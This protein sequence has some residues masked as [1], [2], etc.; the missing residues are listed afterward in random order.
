[1]RVEVVFLPRYL[2]PTHLQ[3]KTVVVFDVLRA[4]TSMAA[5]LAAGVTEIR[6]F[7]DTRSA[8][9]GRAA[10]TGASILSGEVNALPPPGFDLGNS[11]GAFNA[12][13]HAGKT[14]FMSTTNGTV[15][16][17]A[18]RN[19]D[20]VFI[21]ALV[22]AAATARAVA[23]TG[24]DIT[25]LCSGTAGDVS[26]EDLIGCGAV[27]DALSTLG[28]VAC[29]SDAALIAQ[30]LFDASRSDLH[31][32]LCQTRGGHNVVAANLAPDISFAADL[33]RLHVVG[34]LAGDEPAIRR[35]IL[36]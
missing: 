11:P 31:A 30:R 35:A 20:Q 16:L 4:T 24:R 1:M 8:A 15:A 25:L 26:A 36:V 14:M 12:H 9:A 28:P 2:L 7:G 10:Y 5:A 3:N 17:L 22:N 29:A 13:A 18:A 32:A 19:A 21:G 6:I 33:N 27:I 23:A 34:H